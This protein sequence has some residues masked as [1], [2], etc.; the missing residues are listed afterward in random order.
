MADIS[1]IKTPDGTTYDI[2][3]TTARGLVVA[4][5]T[6]AGTESDLTGLQVNGTKYKIPSGGGSSISPYASNPAMD[7]TASPGSSNDY[8][9]GDHVHPTDTTRQAKITA[10]GVLIGNGSGGVT[11]KT[12]DTTSLTDDNNRV[13]TSGVVKSALTQL[14]SDLASIHAT[15]NTN[16]TGATI[17]S[18]TYFYLNDVPVRAKA[19]IAVNAAYT[20]STNYETVP[21]GMLNDL[22]SKV[23]EAMFIRFGD[24]NASLSS[25]LANN[26]KTYIPNDG[27][28]RLVS[29]FAAGGQCVGYLQRYDTV[30]GSGQLTR[31]D[32]YTYAVFMNN[33]SVTVK[34]I[35]HL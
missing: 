15:G 24:W 4:N 10:S 31:W 29:V 6:L 27:I 34:T 30:Y 2:K 14:E 3:D 11:A 22:R 28:P 25:V 20:S 19:D 23:P 26:W 9:R 17:T 13:P 1:K 32:S 8:A 35:T 33:S 12:L 18:G 7:G 5:P 21:D 16:T